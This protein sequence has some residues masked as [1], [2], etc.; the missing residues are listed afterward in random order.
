M[1]ETSTKPA[2]VMARCSG[3]QDTVLQT[4]K[5]RSISV[6]SIPLEE[7]L[8]GLW[9]ILEYV[10]GHMYFLTALLCSSVGPWGSQAMEESLRYKQWILQPP[11]S[12][13]AWLL[14]L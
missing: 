1:W 12:P 10:K 14:S 7:W 6:K 3:I 9:K 8:Q 4:L 5:P 13:P 2:K 11:T